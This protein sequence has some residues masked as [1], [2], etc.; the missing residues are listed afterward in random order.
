ML[1]I[2]MAPA[3]RPHH[4]ELDCDIPDALNQCQNHHNQQASRNRVL[5]DPER[6]AGI[7]RREMLGGKIGTNGSRSPEDKK[8]KQD[9]LGAA[10]AT[11]RKNGSNDC[12]CDVEDIPSNQLQGLSAILQGAT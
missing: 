11:D 5:C 2:E 9:P 1:S 8:N 4:H 6:S 10:I 7:P 12:K 3:A